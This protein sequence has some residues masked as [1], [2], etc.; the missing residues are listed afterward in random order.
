[1]YK[2]I[3]LPLRSKNRFKN[4]W[5]D[6][7]ATLAKHQGLRAVESKQHAVVLEGMYYLCNDKDELIEHFEVRIEVGKEYPHAF[8]VLYEIGGKIKRHID[9]HTSE[10]GLTCVEIAYY[11]KI[12][13]KRGISIYDFINYYVHKFFCWQLVKDYGDGKDL[14]EW[15]H[16][17]PGNI[18][19]YEEICQT[20]DR[21]KLSER[22]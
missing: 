10:A 3:N 7:A 11:E 9:W 22:Y 5:E 20:T 14:L 16:H 13:A 18:Q 12:I 6:L 4:L 19:F 2:S 17:E 15:K 8:P 21:K 1:M